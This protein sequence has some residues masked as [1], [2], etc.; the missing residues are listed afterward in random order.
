MK[1][2]YGVAKRMLRNFWNVASSSTMTSGISYNLLTLLFCSK[3]FPQQ[4]VAS[5]HSTVR[6]YLLSELE[7]LDP[8]ALLTVKKLIQ[9]GLR[10]K[11]D[12]DA[13]NLRESYAQAERF[14]SSIPAERFTKIAAKEI[15]HKL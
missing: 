11:N 12:P 5:F 9:T 6:E 4:S 10:D 2:C 3:I 15:K 1:Y 14:A 13:V 8:V 7:G